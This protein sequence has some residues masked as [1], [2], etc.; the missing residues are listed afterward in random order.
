MSWVTDCLAEKSAAKPPAPSV[1]TA[2]EPQQAT[3]WKAV[4]NVMTENVLEFNNVRVRQFMI[5]ISDRDNIA[6]IV[7]KQP[8]TD[9]AVVEWNPNTRTIQVTCPISHPGL[10]RRGEFKFSEGKIVSVGDFTGEPKPPDS[11]MTPEQFSEMVLKPLLF[12]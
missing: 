7:P 9:T 4:R 5:N 6:Q 12:P 2:V 8:P 3:P 11:P 1:G 10:P